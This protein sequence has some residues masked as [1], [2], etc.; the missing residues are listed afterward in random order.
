MICLYAN[1]SPGNSSIRLKHDETGKGSVSLRLLFV[2]E[3]GDAAKERGKA[4]Q[5]EKLW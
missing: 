2:R 1:G 4:K 5:C 3:G